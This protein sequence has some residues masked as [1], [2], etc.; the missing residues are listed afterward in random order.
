MPPCMVARQHSNT[1]TKTAA[2]GPT[3]PELDRLDRQLKWTLALT[4]LVPLIAISY[5]IHRYGSPTFLPREGTVVL[6]AVVVSMTAGARV[7][8]RLVH[9][10]AGAA[11]RQRA[12]VP[13]PDRGPE[14][15]SI[16]YKVAEAVALIGAIPFLAQGYVMVRYVTPANATESILLL[17]FLV[18]VVICL[19]IV[20]I[21]QLTKRIVRLAVDAGMVRTE[22][23]LPELDWGA[24]EIGGISS[25]LTQIADTLSRRSV[26][27]ENAREFL[28][29]LIEQLPHPLFLTNDKGAIILMNHAVTR[30]LGYES[31][32]L[33]GKELRSVFA[34]GEDMERVL[35]KGRDLVLETTWR[36]R[37]GR[38]IPIAVCSAEVAG[39]D[40]G[41]RVVIVGTDLSE[42]K[43]LEEDLRQSH[44]MEAMG[45]LA[46]GIA[47]DFN[48]ILTAIKGSLYLMTHEREGEGRK[49]GNVESL[50]ESVE[51]AASLV[52]QL[53]AFSRRQILESRVLSLNNVI[54]GMDKLLRRLLGEDIEIVTVLAPD[55]G[56][57]KA[58]KG[59]MEQIIINLSIN[60]RDAMQNG[61]R[62][63]I[64]TDNVERDDSYAEPYP[65]IEPGPQV[66]LS[67]T[68]TGCGMGAEIKSRIF[69]P[70]FTTKVGGRG[71][72]LGLATVYGIVKQHG[73]SIYVYSEKGKG[74][75]FKIY[76]PRVDGET[77]QDRPARRWDEMRGGNETVLLVEDDRSILDVT[78]RA[79]RHQGYTVLTAENGREALAVSSGYG[80]KIDLLIS[81]VVMPLMGGKELA[82]K[83]RSLRPAMKTIYVSGYPDRTIVSDGIVKLGLC[84]MQKPYT[85]QS[86]L[87][88][89]RE[90]LDM[91][92]Q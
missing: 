48:N 57:V 33:V 12:A 59:Q 77:E 21:R 3:G 19:G 11:P 40:R 58:D 7:V 13:P 65:A 76:L 9:R 63:T 36:Q 10:V 61:G 8:L 50:G 70:F 68:D 62:L 23:G 78:S 34:R 26:Q 60:A 49:Q 44:K 82:D 66:R 75:T 87:K 1:M 24:D 53:L 5:L 89:V 56:N 18:T 17:V 30:L 88:K 79:L 22:A 39:E 84:F 86:L 41:R 28:S 91:V 92:A 25:D 90:V 80:G 43:K 83:F 69:E 52:N 2:P 47:H 6:L 15:R 73:G 42:R 14:R 27:L 64:Q 74:T 85:V 16:S 46:G 35:A 31:N 20:E 29:D 72:G 45:L 32:E 71:I 67:V 37:D 54:T 4:T 55:L 38:E 81:D 51:R